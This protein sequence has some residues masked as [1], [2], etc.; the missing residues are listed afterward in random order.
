[1]AKV[2]IIPSTINQFTRLPNT[3]IIK[4]KACGYA[5]VSTDSDEQFTS[6]EA[7][8]DYYTKYIKSRPELEFV[9]VYADEGITAT[10]TKRRDGFNEMIDDALAGKIDL[11][12]AKSVSRFARNTVDSLTTIRKLKDNGVECYFEKENIYT[13]DGKGE[14]M[15]TIMSSLAQEESRSISENVTWGQR[16]RFSDGK[17]KIPIKNFLGYIK[18]KDGTYS[19]NEE[20]AKVIRTIY[21]KFIDGYTPNK[22]GTYLEGLGIK[23]PCGKTKWACSTIVSILKNEKY[24]GDALLQKTFTV[25]F[26]QHKVKKNDGEIPQ[27]YVENSHPAIIPPEEWEIVKLELERRNKIGKAYSSKNCFGSKLICEDCGSFYGPKLWHSTDKYKKVIWL[28]NKKYSKVNK[29]V[30]KT[31]RIEE[32][33]IKNMFIKAYNIIMGNKESLIEDCELIRETLINFDKIDKDISRSCDEVQMLTDAIS[34]LV[35][36][37]ADKVQ[38]QEEYIKKY[39]DLAKRY[40]VEFSKLQELQKN[41]EYRI[42]Q[43]KAMQ[44]FIKQLK[45]KEVKIKSWDEALFALMITNVVVHKDRSIT[46]KFQSGREIRIKA[47]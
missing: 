31:P 40:E 10:N 42:S 12:I 15:I 32:E 26:L 47:E 11:I 45:V 41:K 25:D 27:Y 34:K 7:Q 20:E 4:R 22:I 36:E 17:V 2:T 30:C 1:M 16:K 19:I 5:R 18:E 23:T 44:E 21:R 3:G 28:C 39:N 29:S 14:L 43:N 6:Y 46:F 37:N 24:K 33:Q 38:N 13:F 9:K 35:H 8:V